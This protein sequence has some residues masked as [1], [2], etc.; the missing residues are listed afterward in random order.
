ME[1]TIRVHSLC[2]VSCD[3]EIKTKR[4]RNA[5]FRSQHGRPFSCDSC[6]SWFSLLQFGGVR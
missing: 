3:V 6:H 5:Y 1:I 2:P 4:S